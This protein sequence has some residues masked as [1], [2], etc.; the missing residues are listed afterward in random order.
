[1][2]ERITTDSNV[3]KT[4]DEYREMNKTELLHEYSAL[5]EHCNQ[6]SATVIEEYMVYQPQR[7]ENVKS[8]DEI[9][10]V[11]KG[12]SVIQDLICREETEIEI[13]Q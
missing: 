13:E 10:E 3:V 11:Y 2:S 7:I 12:I 8:W 9:F 1:M 6:V 4:T 5:M